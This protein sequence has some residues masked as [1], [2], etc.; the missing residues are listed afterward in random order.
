MSNPFPND[1]GT[2]PGQPARPAYFPN[3]G[4][5][6]GYVAGCFPNEG[7]DGYPSGPRQPVRQFTPEEIRALSRR[8]R[9]RV[10]NLL[11][12][13]P[14]AFFALW[15]ASLAANPQW[16]NYWG[17]KILTS[18]VALLILALVIRNKV[19]KRRLRQ[20]YF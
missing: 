4:A 13:F 11:L 7:Y 5:D 17:Y 10:V 14:F 12:F 20:K 6:T 18:V 3:P 2:Y 19:V 15:Y 9:L 8:K 1:P 16:N